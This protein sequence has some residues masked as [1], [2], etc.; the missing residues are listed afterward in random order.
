M[1]LLLAAGMT[2]AGATAAQAAITA[3]AGATQ[4]KA[5]QAG[6]ILAQL[7][8]IPGMQVTEKT[9]TIPGYRWFW[10]EYRQPVDHRRP[11][12]SGSSSASCCSTSR[13]TSPWSCTPAATT[14]RK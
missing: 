2:G 8:A 12:G 3:Q 9:S 13:R 10:L 14:R 6:D 4:A 7:K 11:W 5:A 1:A